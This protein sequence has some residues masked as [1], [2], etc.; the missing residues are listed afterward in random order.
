M[1]NKFLKPIVAI[2]FI[3]NLVIHF[4]ESFSAGM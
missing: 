1:L 2:G 4:L 3:V